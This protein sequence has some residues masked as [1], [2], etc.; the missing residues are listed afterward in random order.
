MAIFII[1]KESNGNLIASKARVGES[2]LK[3]ELIDQDYKQV[4]YI[5]DMSLKKKE[6]TII[7]IH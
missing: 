7:R 4:I 3:K 5:D 6:F 1:R 2:I